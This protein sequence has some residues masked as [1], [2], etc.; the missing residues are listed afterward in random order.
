[1]KQ[2]LIDTM[3]FD[4]TPTML[5]EAENKY[6]RF[7]FLGVQKATKTKTVV[8]IQKEFWNE[9]VRSISTEKSKKIVHTVNLTIQNPQSLN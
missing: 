1:M 7:W 3:I 9:N 6:G 5:Q 4:V 8:Y 2:L